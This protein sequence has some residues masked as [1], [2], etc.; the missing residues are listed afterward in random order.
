MDEGSTYTT[1]STVGASPS[2]GGLVDL[3]VL[4]NKA[5][6]VETLGVG[7]GLGV[8]E[9][10][11]EESGR[12]DGPAGLANTPL[13]AYERSANRTRLFSSTMPKFS[14]PSEASQSLLL[15]SH[16]RPPPI[17]IKISI[18]I[19][20]PSQPHPSNARKKIS[21]ALTLS[22]AAFAT[23]V[24]PHG[25]NLG[26]VLNVVEELKGALELHALNGLGGLTGVLEADTQ[27]RAPGAGALCGRNLLSGV[28]DLKRSNPYQQNI[29]PV[30][31]LSR[32][33]TI[34]VVDGE[35][36]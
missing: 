19:K 1:V 36:G 15:L 7:V 30:A 11:R 17:P 10:V 4:D 25:H 29:L 9:E 31:S 18:A 34:F 20:C 22:G 27:V 33:F 16:R 28:T 13:L 2:L 35:I 26:L 12:L 6:G 14:I 32:A 8:L 21:N 24:P 3:D 23:S 5:T